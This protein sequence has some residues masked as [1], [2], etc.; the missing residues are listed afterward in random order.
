MKKKVHGN[1]GRRHSRPFPPMPPSTPVTP[2]RFPKADRFYSRDEIVAI[3]GVSYVTI[4]CW[5]RDNIFP[6]PRELGPPGG[7][8]T[9]I[10][11]LT[12]EVDKW[13]A[14]RPQRQIGGTKK[15]K[16]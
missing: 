14:S 12:S 16:P 4:W 15:A 1:K 13:V 3:T 2:P 11:W 10:G 8:R 5:M 6:K 7:N 9:A